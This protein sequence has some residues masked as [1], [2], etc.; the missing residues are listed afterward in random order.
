M[1]DKTLDHLRCLA[2]LQVIVVHALYWPDFFSSA[3]IN[4]Y[5]SLLLFEMPLF[6]FVSGASSG[7]SREESPW[8]SVRK[9]WLRIL[10]PYWV[11]ALI[12]AAL[13]IAHAAGTAGAVE[14]KEALRIL[15]SWILPINRQITEL[16]YLDYAVWFVPV[17]LAVTA[18]LPLLREMRKSRAG[19][20]ACAF[21]LGL[22]YA[23]SLKAEAGWLRYPAFYLLW[24]FAGLYYPEIR[25]AGTAR[26]YLPAALSALALLGLRLAGQNLDMQ[27]HKFPPDPVFLVFSIFWMSLLLAGRKGL[28]AAMDRAQR[29]PVLSRLVDCFSHR[30]T[31]VFLYQSFAFYASAGISTL[32]V[33]AR[34]PWIRLLVCFPLTL[35][36]CVLLA[37]VFGPIEGRIRRRGKGKTAGNDCG[38]EK[39]G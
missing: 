8:T 18:V 16:P 30:T 7:Y 1:R 35:L 15:L 4:L 14:G 34:L 31:T 28:D 2:M 37:A 39:P 6:F 38:E 27:V 13:S 5:K 22:L 36:F 12:C 24:T 33:P 9:R 29:V 3:R 23:L 10:I 21:A 25:R 19:G 17:Y 32:L 11:Y 26:W 20:I